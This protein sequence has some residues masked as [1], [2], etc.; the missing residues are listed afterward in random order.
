MMNQVRNPGTPAS[1][2]FALKIVMA[3][4]IQAVIVMGVVLFFVTQ[5]KTPVS[6]TSPVALV[7][8]TAAFAI[9]FAGVGLARRARV[10]RGWVWSGPTLS[11]SGEPLDPAQIDTAMTYLSRA[12]VS[13][14]IAMAMSELPAIIGLLVGLAF[15]AHYVGY[16]LVVLGLTTTLIS[17]V[18]S[19][20][21]FNTTVALEKLEQ[22]ARTAQAR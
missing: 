10:A 17:G 20:P 1:Q 3:A 12:R 11:P 14:L 15:G 7:L 18:S 19:F 4:F 21:I 2:A 9:S 6:P 8:A 22:L 16:G 5:G 13:F